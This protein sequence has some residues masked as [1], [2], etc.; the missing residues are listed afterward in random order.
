MPSGAACPGTFD[1][2]RVNNPTLRPTETSDAAWPG[3]R[4]RI[5]ATLRD[6]TRNY[7]VMTAAN[8]HHDWRAV[9]AARTF[10]YRCH[11]LAA[12]PVTASPA[13]DRLRIQWERR[14]G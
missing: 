7:P 5:V 8:S 12:P 4:S 6:I 3:H 9:Y 14:H 1:T 11:E 2:A 10:Q 13:G